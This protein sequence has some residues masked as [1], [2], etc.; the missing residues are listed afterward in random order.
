[1]TTPERLT[2]EFR[3]RR[4]QM[5]VYAGRPGQTYRVWWQRYTTRDL[6]GPLHEYQ[7]GDDLHLFWVGEADLTEATP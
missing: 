2:I 7:I 1:M 3:Y 4:G 6:L 5:V